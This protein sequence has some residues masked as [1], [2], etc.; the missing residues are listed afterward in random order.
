M[1]RV[2][3]IDL[4]PLAMKYEGVFELMVMW[5]EESD[6]EL[7]S[8]II[9][10]LQEEIDEEEKSEILSPAPLKEEYLHFDNL[11]EIAKDIMEFKKTL[12]IEVDRWGG[13]NQLAKETGIPQPSLSRFFTTPSLPRRTTLE[14]IAKALSLKSSAFLSK[15]RLQAEGDV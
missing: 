14:K 2:E 5:S 4:F 7:K 11:D 1:M 8:D 6:R 3:K 10:D 9:A 12:K 13:I 15:Y